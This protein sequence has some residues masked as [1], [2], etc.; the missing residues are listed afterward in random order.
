MEGWC[1]FR[2]HQYRI[3]SKDWLALWH[4]YTLHTRNANSAL[5]EKQT[6]KEIHSPSSFASHPDSDLQF[7]PS[8]LRVPRRGVLARILFILMF[9]NFVFFVCF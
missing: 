1:I 3:P 7:N 8:L 9:T 5:E 4:R 6:G 2:R